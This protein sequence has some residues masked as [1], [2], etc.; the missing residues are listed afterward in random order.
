MWVHFHLSPYR[1]QV[2]S[3]P[4]IEDVFFCPLYIFGFFV[5]DQVCLSVWFYFWVFNPIPLINNMFFSVPTPCSFYHYCSVVKLEIR[6][7]DSPS[8][9]FIVKICFCYSAV[10]FCFVLFCFVFCL[11]R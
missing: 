3:A 4:Y 7:G 8:S 10:L 11:L 5:K 6:N 1:Q 9:S 2:R